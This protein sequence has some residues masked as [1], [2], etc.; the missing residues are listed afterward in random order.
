MTDNVSSSCD[1]VA[2][3]L[4][5]LP[6]LL[7]LGDAILELPHGSFPRSS[8]LT[9]FVL[10][11]GCVGVIC[12]ICRDRPVGYSSVDF[13]A[14]SGKSFSQFVAHL[15]QIREIVH[16]AASG[17]LHLDGAHDGDRG[18]SKLYMSILGVLAEH[19][20]TLSLLN[21]YVSGKILQQS[22]V[23]LKLFSGFSLQSDFNGVLAAG[24]LWKCL[25][26][27]ARLHNARVV[28]SLIVDAKLVLALEAHTHTIPNAWL[29]Q[30]L[31]EL[32]IPISTVP[33]LTTT[34]CST[35]TTWI[36]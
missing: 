30:L 33:L 3:S 11:D 21:S 9:Y 2:F 23:L 36:A 6:L 5:L 13:E 31:C 24:M 7:S 12:H 1:H 22:R 35:Q 34:R 20:H 10:L 26:E 28:G 25:A 18:V 17:P 29:G 4:T 8:A 32:P 27:C 14:T 19:F 15:A 16:D